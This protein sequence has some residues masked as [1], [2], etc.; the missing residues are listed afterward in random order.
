M[1]SC[2]PKSEGFGCQRRVRW[3]H[4]PGRQQ[5]RGQSASGGC[6][7]ARQGAGGLD[8]AARARIEQIGRLA[9]RVWLRLPR[10]RR[11]R[12]R[13]R[14]RRWRRLRGGQR[15]RA[16]E[17][18]VDEGVAAKHG[19]SPMLADGGQ[20]QAHDGV[21]QHANRQ[22]GDQVVGHQRVFGG[23]C[24]RRRLDDD[25]ALDLACGFDARIFH[26]RQGQLVG[27]AR[28]FGLQ[29]QALEIDRQLVQA[30][31]PPVV[32]GGA[33]PR[34]VSICLLQRGDAAAQRLD[35]IASRRSGNE[36]PVAARPR[37]VSATLQFGREHTRGLRLQ[38]SGR[39]AC[40]CSGMPAGRLRAFCRRWLA[41]AS[42]VSAKRSRLAR[43]AV[44]VLV[45]E[46]LA[47]LEDG[48]VEALRE[49]RVEALDA[50]RQ[51]RRAIVVEHLRRARGSSRRSPPGSR[52]RHSR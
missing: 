1:K 29:L 52:R 43:H 27:V 28:E 6:H 3:Q 18:Q 8:Q 7:A 14:G 5:R 41:S 24:E 47:L 34:S 9:R 50:H 21:G 10:H 12:R 49:R 36:Q 11:G 31:A 37:A 17:H 30:V 46:A 4:H 26:R 15:R 39:A 35:L 13:R 22:Q 2:E 51:Q 25:Q 48:L 32:F 20:H 16:G 42:S 40:S 38:R 33:A 45:D 19:V 44:R 23:L